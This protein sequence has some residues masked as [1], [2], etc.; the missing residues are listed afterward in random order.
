MLQTLV[1]DRVDQPPPRLAAIDQP[2]ARH[3]SVGEGDDAR[4]AVERAGRDKA[5]RQPLM[6]RAE[7]ANRIPDV[8]SRGGEGNVVV[9]GGHEGVLGCVRFWSRTPSLR[10]QRSNPEMFPRLESGLLR[11]KC[12]SQ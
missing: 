11:R 5:R 10:A 6:Q 2:L 1:V 3:R 4:V 7:I 12:S 8:V 9:D